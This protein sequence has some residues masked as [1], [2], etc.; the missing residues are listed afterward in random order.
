M[1]TPHKFVF[2]KVA[3]PSMFR[4]AIILLRLS[5]RRVVKTVAWYVCVHK[6]SRGDK[7]KS[8]PISSGTDR[9]AYGG[10]RNFN[11]PGRICINFNLIVWFQCLPLRFFSQDFIYT[12]GMNGFSVELFTGAKGPKLKGLKA[13]QAEPS[14]LLRMVGWGPRWAP[15]C[16][17]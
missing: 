9:F 6:H 10:Q 12:C 15:T 11:I 13:C 5:W 7:L 17:S 4:S 2:W 8:G 3:C 14:R 1:T 16:C